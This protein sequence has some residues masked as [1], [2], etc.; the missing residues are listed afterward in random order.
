MR[1]PSVRPGPNSGL[2]M[3]KIW[4]MPRAQRM[5]WPMCSA[6][7][8]VASPPASGIFR[9]ALSQPCRCSFSAVCASSVTVS[10]AKPPM[11]ASA[12]RRSTAH[13]PQ[14]NAAFQ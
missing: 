2:S 13:E 7:R 5:R 3:R 1:W 4:I 8:S 6:S 11:S 12:A 10:T 9:Y 14:K